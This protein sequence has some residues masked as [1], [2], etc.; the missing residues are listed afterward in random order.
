MWFE[1]YSKQGFTCFFT[2]EELH[3][4]NI[5]LENLNA[6][7]V[8][9]NKHK[10]REL[11][12]EA[13]EYAN[14]EYGCELFGDLSCSV[15][16]T[17]D[18]GLCFKIRKSDPEKHFRKQDDEGSIPEG[19]QSRDIQIIN[20]VRLYNGL[21]LFFSDIAAVGAYIRVVQHAVE[22]NSNILL[23]LYKKP[24]NQRYA[25][26]IAHLPVT[27]EDEKKELA[28]RHV[29][30]AAFE[31]ADRVY[32]GRHVMSMAAELDEHWQLA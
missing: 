17:P 30:F 29:V 20:D 14:K 27:A 8:H 5:I 22:E 2:P 13:I 7:I 32:T 26:D 3:D 21:I 12:S 6:N 1:N 25:L 11:I 18:C 23:T 4:R 28:L 15:H 9:E 24:G 16:V 19:A 10:I 31:Y